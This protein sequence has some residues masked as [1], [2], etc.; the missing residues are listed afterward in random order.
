[1]TGREVNNNMIT[2]ANTTTTTS[3]KFDT[4]VVPTFGSQHTDGAFSEA[5]AGAQTV[6]DSSEKSGRGAPAPVKRDRP[7]QGHDSSHDSIHRD[8]RNS[9]TDA[10]DRHD[11]PTTG[12]DRTDSKVD[13]S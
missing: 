4:H 3:V 7:D 8:D 1:M 12:R 11:T 9:S 6:L 13:H 10:T 2:Q 5:L